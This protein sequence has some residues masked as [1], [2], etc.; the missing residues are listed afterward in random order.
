MSASEDNEL[1]WWTLLRRAFGIPDIVSGAH[2]EAAI[3]HALIQRLPPAQSSSS[4]FHNPEAERRELS[5]VV[6]QKVAKFG[7][8]GRLDEL[9]VALGAARATREELVMLVVQATDNSSSEGIVAELLE[10]VTAYVASLP[11]GLGEPGT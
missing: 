1:R 6:V 11:P 9:F 5:G 4:R 10:I 2:T 3:T 8:E 7:G